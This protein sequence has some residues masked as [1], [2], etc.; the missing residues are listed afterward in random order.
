MTESKK[1]SPESLRAP[2]NCG[3][4]AAPEVTGYF[5]CS[6]HLLNQLFDSVVSEQHKRFTGSNCPI[7]DQDILFFANSGSYNM[8]TAALYT[9]LLKNSGGSASKIILLQQMLCKYS[10]R[11]IVKAYLPE[12]VEFLESAEKNAPE[13]PVVSGLGI[14]DEMN[15]DDPT[16]DDLLSTAYLAGLNLICSRTAEA[17]GEHVSA[18]KCMAVYQQIKAAFLKKFYSADLRFQGSSQTAKIAALYFDL[19]PDDS[20]LWALLVEDLLKDIEKKH[21]LHFSAGSAGLSLILPVLTKSEAL[22]TAYSLL[23]QSS[24]PSWLHPVIRGGKIDDNFNFYAFGAAV[25]WFYE[26]ICGIQPD[27]DFKHFKLDPR[28]GRFLEWASAEYDS[29]YGPVIS[30]WHREGDDYIHQFTI[31]ENT[32]ALVRNKLYSSGTYTIKIKH[33]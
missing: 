17:V 22:D 20:D 28:F 14:K 15:F 13:F 2:Q 26:G 8:N 7:C 11:E 6:N 12:T 16:P 24:F 4:K 3:S 1:V 21:K 29:I 33:Y 10:D 27:P 5:R 32:E 31:P 9:E 23:Q 25:S 18:A 19:C 30:T